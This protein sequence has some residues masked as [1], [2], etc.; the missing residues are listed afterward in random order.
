MK[1]TPNLE[2]I[3][4]KICIENHLNYICFVDAGNF[5]EIFCVEVG[6]KDYA[7]KV[8]NIN[9]S[10]ERTQ[11][12]ID[13]MKRMNC[14]YI[15]KLIKVDEISC[16]EGRFLY[17]LEEYLGGGNL[18]KRI[19]NGL[20]NRDE[21]ILLGKHMIEALR[22]THSHNIVHRDIKP[23]N[24]LYRKGDNTSI[25]VDFGLVRDLSATSLTQAFQA[26]GPGTPL[27]SAPEQLNNQKALIDWRTDQFSLGITLCI[28]FLGKHPFCTGNDNAIKI[29]ETIS[30]HNRCTTA[31][32]AELIQNKLMPIVKMIEPFPVGRYTKPDFLASEW[33]KLEEL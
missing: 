24:I 18:T 12:E 28:A 14:D 23:D 22:T 30:S 10:P 7:L 29:I 1:K 15:V 9:N 11:R 4:Q 5:K 16:S 2:N 17:L 13:V 21:I 33:N 25:L 32:K 26:C 6:G 8:F 27:Y 20:L 3:A 31:I 19:A